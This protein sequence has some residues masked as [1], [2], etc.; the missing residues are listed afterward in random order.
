MQKA[1]PCESSENADRI[2]AKIPERVV[3]GVSTTAAASTRTRLKPRTSKDR[4]NM[5]AMA[6]SKKGYF[7]ESRDDVTVI[8]MWQADAWLTP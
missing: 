1:R 3:K 8:T 5:T 7:K 6:K 2:E 4:L